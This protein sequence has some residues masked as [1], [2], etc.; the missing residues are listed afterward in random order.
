MINWLVSE[1]RG[2]RHILLLILSEFE[3]INQLHPEIIRKPLQFVIII[4]ANTLL[5]SSQFK[6]KVYIIIY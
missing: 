6:L 5:V 3:Q 4:I 1:V 2:H